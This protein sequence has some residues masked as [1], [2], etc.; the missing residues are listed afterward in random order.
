VYTVRD[1]FEK[2]MLFSSARS[3]PPSLPIL[4][5]V[6]QED[7][8]VKRRKILSVLTRAQ[9]RAVR[10]AITKEGIAT[11]GITPIFSGDAPVFLYVIGKKEETE[12][13]S[14]R[15]CGE[16]L[17]TLMKVYPYEKIGIAPGSLSCP[18]FSILQEGVILG[19]YEFL[20]YKGKKEE[21][22]NT[23]ETKLREISF[24][25]AN[26]EGMVRSQSVSEGV[27]LTKDIINTPPSDANPEYVTKQCEALAKK[28]RKISISIFEEKELQ[29]LGCGGILGVGRG[30]QYSPRLVL[31][32][33]KGSSK[34]EQPIV[35]VGKGVTFDTGGNNIKGRH[36]RWMKQDLGGCA[37]V[38]GAFSSAINLEIK[39]NITAV[40]P[41][42]EN[43]VDKDSYFP[44]D[45]LKM[46]NGITV[47]VDN[48]D[49]EGRLILADA[50]AYA[51]DTLRPRAIVDLATLTG[52]CMYAVGNDFTAGMTN[53][54]HLFAALK[55]ASNEVN[56]PL[57]ELPLHKRYIKQ[58]FKSAIADITNCGGGARAGTI[59]G[60]LFLEHFVGEDIPWCHMDIASVAFDEKNGLATGRNVRL[61]VDFL[62]KF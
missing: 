2:T 10:F 48:T 55:K 22:K 25:S 32:Q 26:K 30:S 39:K 46:Y 57:W 18:S 14:I 62:E 24:I 56:E 51:S 54:K 13:R 17:N 37:T 44:D 45:V 11:S 60:G 47:E 43:V 12:N 21:E 6:Y 27:K 34:K 58:Y 49:A 16:K 20:D 53:D 50:L 40:L 35:L 7:V 4:L 5:P 15:E 59:E 31:L 33:Y 41:V 1:F 3:L 38:L 9:K 52:A 28:S 29:K 8:Q 61:L 36:M 19:G 42:V 23:P